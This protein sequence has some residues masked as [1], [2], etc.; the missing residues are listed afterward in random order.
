MGDLPAEALKTTTAIRNLYE[1]NMG[2][3]V[4]GGKSRIHRRN[5]QGL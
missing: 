5:L 1:G 4:V 2:A 3:P